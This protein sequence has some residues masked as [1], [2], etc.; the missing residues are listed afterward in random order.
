MATKINVRSPYYWSKVYSVP[1]TPPPSSMETIINLFIWEGQLSSVPSTPKY[2]L[3]SP[4]VLYESSATNWYSTFE[5]S[6]LVRGYIDYT[7]NGTYSSQCVWVAINVQ[8]TA[9]YE[10]FIAVDGY[11]YYEEGANAELSRSLMISNTFI[12]KPQGLPTRVPIFG[13]DGISVT[14]FSS[15]GSFISNTTTSAST[16]T[17][18]IVKNFSVPSTTAYF[19]VVNSTAGESTTV[20][21]KNMNCGIHEERKITF[22]NKFGALQDVYF[23]AKEVGGVSVNSTT[24]KPN[25]M[26]LETKS[27]STTE[28]HNKILDINGVDSITLSTGFVSEDYNEVIKQ[29]M[30]SEKVWMTRNS[31][32][33]P[34]IVRT[35]SVSYQ[36]SLN[37]KLVS[38]TIDFDYAFDSIQSVR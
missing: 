21:V 26:N 12:W 23:F 2:V 27:Y 37:D 18:S 10:Y 14:F 20:Q 15:T 24:Y 7:F 16:N 5:I 22:L 35:N 36:T 6:E 25:I 3:R 28:H 29:M 4:V 8:G 33:Y 13:N 9:T 38:Y 19:I 17:T 30:L 34:M 31:V 32:V 1:S 11:G